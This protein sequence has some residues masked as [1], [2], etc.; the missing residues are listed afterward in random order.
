ML[1]YTLCICIIYAG[2]GMHVCIYM[3]C[4]SFLGIYFTYQHLLHTH[5]THM[6]VYTHTHLFPS[7][8]RMDCLFF[9]M[10]IYFERDRHR[11][12]VG[13]CRERGRYRIRSRHQTLSCQHRARRTHECEIM[14]WAEVRCSTDWATQ[15]P[16][17]CLLIKERMSWKLRQAT[18]SPNIFWERCFYLGNN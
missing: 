5:T 11:V 13:E 6:Y 1:F 14:T 15:A 9:L 4:K 7:L 10:F 8:I 18:V 16:L 17:D 2:V 12:W 3:A